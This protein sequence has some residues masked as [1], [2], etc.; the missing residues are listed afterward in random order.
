[1]VAGQSAPK[2]ELDAVKEDLEA[3]RADLEALVKAVSDSASDIGK[4][5]FEAAKAK[6]QE[7][8]DAL[9]KQVEERPLASIALSFGVGLLLGILSRR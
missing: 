2:D 5:T 9:A 7:N 4:E 8:V 6:G 3:L 1:M